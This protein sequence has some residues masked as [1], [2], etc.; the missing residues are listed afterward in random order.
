LPSPDPIDGALARIHRS[1]LRYGCRD[2]ELGARLNGGVRPDHQSL[3]LFPMAAHRPADL[4]LEA[5][6]AA[7]G[8]LAG[9]TSTS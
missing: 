6:P 1:S 9:P 5:Q 2:D 3:V 4:L 8:L 7:L